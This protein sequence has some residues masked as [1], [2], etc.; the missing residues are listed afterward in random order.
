[1]QSKISEFAF[2][3]VPVELLEEAGI[4]EGDVMQMSVQ[5]GKLVIEAADI[6]KE[7][8]VCDGD[9]ENCPLL[10]MGCD[11]DCGNCPCKVFYTESEVD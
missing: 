10:G 4:F 9:C 7:E 5:K 1:M 3:S 8:I 6:D 2:V 11:D